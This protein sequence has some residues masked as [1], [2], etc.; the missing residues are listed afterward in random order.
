M[1]RQA[2][3]GGILPVLKKRGPTSHDVVDMARHALRERQIGH[4]G[5]LDPAAEGLLV[6]CLGPY[7][8]LVPYLIDSDKSYCGHFALGVETTT[9]DSE[10]E[11]TM[12]ADAREA[13][14]ERLRAAAARFTGEIEQM[15]PRYAA[16]KVAGKKLYE[17]ARENQEVRVEARQVTV[18]SLEL[19]D[20]EPMQAPP[21]MVAR[22]TAGAFAGAAREHAGH[23]VKVG[24]RTRVTS[25]T[26]VRALA[27]DLGRAMGCGGYLLD[28]VR[29]GVGQFTTDTAM[30]LDLL[31][32]EPLRVHEY[33]VRGAA[34]LDSRRYP[35]V[36]IMRAYVRRLMNGQPLNEKMME[37]SASAA[38]VPSGAV[39]AIAGEEGGLLAMA[40]AERFDAMRKANPYDSRFDVHFKP[41]RIFPRGLA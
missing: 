27:R 1:K 38:A 13:T 20:C 11:P 31:E 39:C 36:T 19:V 17:Y 3:I 15:P 30:S 24:F 41:L 33:L 35:I 10:G 5:T 7:T 8:K 34:T 37:N 23:L 29:D 14:L 4:T 25:G 32:K 16:I 21:E 6:L 22:A 2:T 40:E 26:Y 12:F 9:D 28:L 18:H